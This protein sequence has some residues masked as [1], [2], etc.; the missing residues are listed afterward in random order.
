[1]NEQQ[2]PWAQPNVIALI[3]VIVG[4]NVV[5]DWF[6]FRPKSWPLF[7]FVEIIFLGVVIGA[8]RSWRLRS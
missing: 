3:G 7:I 1:M 4:I 6:V 2:R 5:A 8:V